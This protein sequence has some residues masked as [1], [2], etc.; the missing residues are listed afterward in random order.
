MVEANSSAGSLL[1]G[2]E[3]E[4][5]EAGTSGN[6]R[7]EVERMVVRRTSRDVETAEKGTDVGK[8]SVVGSRGREG[9]NME[10]SRDGVAAVRIRR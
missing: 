9:G 10:K 5:K 3:R 8:E 4:R 1:D 2:K 7:Q 6:G